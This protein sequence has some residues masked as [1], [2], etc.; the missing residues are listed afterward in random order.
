MPLTEQQLSNLCDVGITLIY[1][2]GLKCT[3]MDLVAKRLQI[4][5]RTL[6]ENYGSKKELLAAALDHI[7]RRQRADF[8]RIIDE[9]ENSV[10]ALSQMME[11]HRKVIASLNVRFFRDMDTLYN[12]VRPHFEE[13]KKQR[14]AD[15]TLLMQ[16]GIQEGLFRPEL[17]YFIIARMIELQMESLKRMEDLFP[18]DI[19]IVEVFDTI[20]STVLRGI[21]TPAGL[22][23]LENQSTKK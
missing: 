23:I 11:S 22:E 19:S 12:E 16:R 20:Y 5:K 8:R 21:L 6:Y 13:R 9:S 2:K 18:D 14:E 4:S 10:V 1:E 7:N 17:N 15:M 3:T